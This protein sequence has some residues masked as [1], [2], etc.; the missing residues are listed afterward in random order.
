ML[1]HPARVP[2]WAGLCLLL[3]GVI[4]A[5]NVHGES[6]DINGPVYEP[7]ADDRDL[8]PIPLP[9]LAQTDPV[10]QR[11]LLA[12][13]AE[14][15]SLV[16]QREVPRPD[17][18]E[19]YGEMGLLYHAHLVFAAAEPC[20]RNAHSLAPDDPRWPYYLA[21]LSEQ[22]GRL[23]QAAAGYR[24]T[25]EIQPDHAQ[26]RL[27][28]G[29]IYLE[30]DR[31]ALAEPLFQASTRVEKLQG[32][33]LF[34]LGQLALAQ[35]DPE[36]AIRLLQQALVVSP[37]A[38]QMHYPLAMAYRAQGD[39]KRARYHLAKRG[40]REPP[41][42]DPLIDALG[43]L[44]AG[45]DTLFHYAMSAVRRK[46]YEVAI[47][48]LTQVLGMEPGSIASRVSL[49]RALYLNGDREAAK[50]RLAESLTQEPDHGLANFLMGVLYD[51]SGAAELANTYFRKTLSVEPQHGGAH[52]FL[53]NLLVRAGDHAAAT[54]HYHMAVQHDPENTPARLGEIRALG[55]GGA[56]HAKIQDRLEAAHERFPGHTEFTYYLALLLVASPEAGVRDVSRALALAKQLDET[57]R[58]PQHA[59]VMAMAHARL[60]HF[61]QAVVVQEGALAAAMALNRFDLL[62]RL[63]AGL[64]RYREGRPSPIVWG[65]ASLLPSPPVSNALGAFRDYPG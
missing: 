2:C 43:R 36:R 49:A 64:T 1:A 13:R 12:A 46:Q 8:L 35:K 9:N 45:P 27:R 29:Q 28:L 38:S 16:A 33:A 44:A 56:P 10:V 25:L 53:A 14:L 11:V 39:L 65:E 47:E 58:L 32:A 15:D 41:I 30:L 59:E 19:A 62:L 34:G 42:P 55:L 23:E 60:G 37:E 17:L 5:S 4:A 6:A 50:D 21:Y 26:A 51:E 7:V 54:R 3:L 18:A 40:N 24:G 61:E 63:G 52:F 48:A 20:Y 31:F 57:R 22:N